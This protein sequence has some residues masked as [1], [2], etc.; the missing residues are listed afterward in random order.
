MTIDRR[1]LIAGGLALGGGLLTAPALAQR[2][3][4]RFPIGFRWG[5][6]TSGGQNEGNNVNSDLWLLENTKPTVFSEPSGDATNSFELWRTDLDLVKS[7]GLNTFRFSLEWAR[8][9]P[10]EGRF[11]IAML[12]HYKAI[13]DGCRA[14]G[15]APVVTYCHYSSPR[16]LAARGGW[17]YPQAPAL[18][19]RFCERATR[20]LGEGIDHAA[21]LNEP[22]IMGVLGVV[23][24][25]QAAFGIA[26]ML[27]GAAKTL[28]TDHLAAINA[29]KTAD[30]P[31]MF[32][33]LLAAHRAGRQAIKSVR[34]DLPVG[35]TL[36]MFDDEAVGAPTQRDAARTRLYGM[37]LDAA[38][39]DDFVG[40]QNYERV[41]W[42]AQGRLPPP[43]GATLTLSGGEIYAPSLANACRYAY[44]QAKVPILVTEHG[45]ATKD[46]RIRATLIRQALPELL[47]AMDEGVPIKGY[48]H[49]TLIDNWE[50]VSGYQGEHGLAS[51]DHTTF[52]RTPKPSAAVLGAIARRNAL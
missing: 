1:S 2:G 44:S 35:M 16:W 41:L 8:I 32:K 26:A 33:I 37:W 45:A 23:L 21:T 12:D 9:E 38:R 27:D 13:I 19:A 34:P 36:A 20:H 30:V 15:I 29:A 17:L 7:I 6:A 3:G 22:N 43:K 14:R 4:T 18:F 28:G 40:V 39:E 42:G 31:A 10:E 50:F 46:D 25:P 11:S 5:A 48:I 52:K 24:P 49:W 51:F 47:R